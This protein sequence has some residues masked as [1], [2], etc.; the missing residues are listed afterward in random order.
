[1]YHQI[2]WYRLFW[3]INLYLIWDDKK[4]IFQKQIMG[5]IKNIC[6]NVSKG[7]S[8]TLFKF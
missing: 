4:Y 3:F 5:L 1:M 2:F 6:V 8:D 7:N